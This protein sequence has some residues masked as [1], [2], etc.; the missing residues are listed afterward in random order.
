MAE[1]STTRKL[2]FDYK[3]GIWDLYS[4]SIIIQLARPMFF[5]WPV[6][7]LFN[8]YGGY[9]LLW[10]QGRPLWAFAALAG[11][12]LISTGVL[13][14]AG[15]LI[16]LLNKFLGGN[17]KHTTHHI[18]D[19]HGLTEV[20]AGAQIVLPYESV[21]RLIE[22]KNF[23]VLMR[24]NMAG[25]I[26]PKKVLPP[27][28]QALIREKV[29]RR[30]WVFERLG[31]NIGWIVLFLMA[32]VGAALVHP[33]RLVTMTL[34][35]PQ[36]V[37]DGRQVVVSAVRS[38]NGSKE[39]ILAALR[40]HGYRPQH[41]EETLVFVYDSA[42]NKHCD[43]VAIGGS[44]LVDRGGKLMLSPSYTSPMPETPVAHVI[45]DCRLK[46]MP[47]PGDM[48]YS[49]DLDGPW[50]RLNAWDEVPELKKP[51][52]Y[53]PEELTGT[54]QTV[55]GTVQVIFSSRIQGMGTVN[56]S[57]RWSLGL[58]GV[59][60]KARVLFEGNGRETQVDE[61]SYRALFGDSK[62]GGQ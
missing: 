45:E 62:K 57:R 32:V 51:S 33:Y 21:L 31:S 44:Q 6:L 55:S 56:F 59:D 14:V 60:G 10:S 3:A 30:D 17:F 4:G 8:G 40:G 2:E 47:V 26:L 41:K 36:V 9:K 35:D 23:F 18:L 61:A 7:G 43:L 13:F 29:A 42:T 5:L 49:E 27:E 28:F 20:T 1:A 12:V 19:E 16:V 38:Q 52:F 11:G 24:G 34:E 46:P 50:K 25:Q 15:M 39:V 54:V 22:T 48:V 37:S 53:G 58:V